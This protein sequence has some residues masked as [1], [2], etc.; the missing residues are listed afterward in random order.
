MTEDGEALLDRAG[1]DPEESVLT[2][3]QAEVLALRERDVAQADIAERLGTSRAN[4]AGIEASARE[5]VRRARATVDF[6]DAIRAPVRLT[7]EPGTDVYEIPD[8][9]YRAAD[10]ADVKVSLSAVGVIERLTEAAREALDSR[11]LTRPVRVTVAAD[12][13]VRFRVDDRS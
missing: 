11:R 10:E 6:V 3:R 9:V 12:G 5:N 2:R 1:F 8:R 7:V 4:V 13:E